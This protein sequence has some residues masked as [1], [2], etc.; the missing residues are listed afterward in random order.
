MLSKPLTPPGNTVSY[1]RVGG[2]LSGQDGE[3]LEIYDPEKK[4]SKWS[5][6]GDGGSAR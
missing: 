3:P 2:W 4:A 5:E 1:L 6:L